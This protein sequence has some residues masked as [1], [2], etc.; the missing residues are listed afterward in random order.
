MAK[1]PMRC[2]FNEKMCEECQLFR[3]RHYYLC[4]NVN[5]RGHI[6]SN[7]KIDNSGPAKPLDIDAIKRLFEPWSVAE[8]N[9]SA[10]APKLKLKVMYM[11]NGASKVCD[12][13][14]AETWEWEDPRTMRIVNGGHVA[15]LSQ[16]MEIVR[17]QEAKGATEITII[18]AP[19]FMLA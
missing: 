17:Y 7:K 8:K 10:A 3:G 11:E 2:P 1:L 14:E 19:R 13:A 18:E 4:A 12:A 5:Y 9:P 6:K 16:L 15:S